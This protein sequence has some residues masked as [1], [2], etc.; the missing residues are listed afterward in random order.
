MTRSVAVGLAVLLFASVAVAPA[1]GASDAGPTR[2]GAPEGFSQTVFNIQ[3]YEN[4][5]AQWTFEYSRP[6]ENESEREQF[7]AFAAEFEANESGMYRDFVNRSTKL[8]TAGSDVTGR[9]MNAASFSRSASVDETTLSDERGVVTMSFTWSNFGVTD[10]DTVRAGD[11]FEGGLY[12]GQNQRLV[13]ETG[14]SLAF[15][16]ADPESYSQSGDTLESSDT[17]TWVGEKQF[18][19]RR[20]RVELVDESALGGGNGDSAGETTDSSTDPGNANSGDML[21]LVGALVV[22]I[23]LAGAAVWQS[24]AFSGD[25]GPS[26]DAAG[27]AGAAGEPATTDTEPAAIPDEELLS[28]NDRV[29]KLLEDNG[30]RMKQVNIVDET[31]WSKSKVSMLLS[32]ME[33]EGDISKLRVGRENI[34]SLSGHEPEAAGSPFDDEE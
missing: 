8:T 2:L 33:D 20:P 22:V 16:S 4:G 34:I 29:L 1:L 15:R 9:E 17:V 18:T 6:L 13:F 5:S 25:D 26:D 10:G 28:D 14:P 27:A 11:V 31:E 32:E 24:G 19:D 23:G 21:V 12:I 30:G 3:M 7:E